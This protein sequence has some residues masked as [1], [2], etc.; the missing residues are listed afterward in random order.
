VSCNDA[1]DGS[2]VPASF[3]VFLLL[4][5]DG[6]KVQGVIC[7][8][9]YN[10]FVGKMSFPNSIADHSVMDEEFHHFFSH[11]CIYMHTNARCNVFTK[12]FALNNN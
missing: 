1:F 4:F 7:R 11:G 5:C 10:G 8:P 3:E 9:N 2:I 12:F 6:N